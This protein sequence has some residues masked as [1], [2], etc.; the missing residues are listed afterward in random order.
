MSK[1][2]WLTN[3]KVL[4][5]GGMCL[6]AIIFIRSLPGLLLLGTGGAI[7]YGCAKIENKIKRPNQELPPGQSE[8]VLGD[9]N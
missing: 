9:G 8:N 6:V 3:P 4:L 1:L 2:S 5:A 7:G